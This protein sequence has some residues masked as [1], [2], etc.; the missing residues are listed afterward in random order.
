MLFGFFLFSREEK[1]HALMGKPLIKKSFIVI[2]LFLY[3]IFNFIRIDSFR[4]PYLFGKALQYTHYVTPM[5]DWN[6]YGQRPYNSQ[7]W[8]FVEYKADDNNVYKIFEESA[9][10]KAPPL[11][12]GIDFYQYSNYLLNLGKLNDGLAKYFCILAKEK[13]PQFKIKE[14]AFSREIELINTNG[15]RTTGIN[16]LSFFSPCD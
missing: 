11:I 16:E 5:K 8:F 12:E 1:Q 10:I 4:Y 7:G 9:T 3:I 13:T 14:V 2:P 6:I 15:E